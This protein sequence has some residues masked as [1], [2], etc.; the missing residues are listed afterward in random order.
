[1]QMNPI[2]KKKTHTKRK[3]VIVKRDSF[4]CVTRETLSE[5]QLKS[6]FLNGLACH[7]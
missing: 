7:E 2:C 1:M 5:I 6:F 3:K 4:F